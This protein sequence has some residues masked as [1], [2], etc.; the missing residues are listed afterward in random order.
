VLIFRRVLATFV[1]AVTLPYLLAPVYRFP[2][3]Q[4]FTGTALWNPYAHVNATWHRANLH[5]HGRSWGGLT[6]GSQLDEDVVQAYHQRGYAVAG[7]SDYHWIAAQHGVD[8][9]PLYEHGYNI[10]KTHQLAI[11]AQSRC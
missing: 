6:N 7:V 11:G 4:Q 1:L 9:L 3:R 5:A 10:A 2:P 8:T